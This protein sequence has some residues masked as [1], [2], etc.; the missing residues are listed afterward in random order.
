MTFSVF[1]RSAGV[2]AIALAAVVLTGLFSV[3]AVP[4][5][6]PTAVPKSSKPYSID[7]TIVPVDAKRQQFVSTVQVS[8]LSTGKVLLTIK[9]VSHIGERADVRSEREANG[10][11]YGFTI[12]IDPST[13]SAIYMLVIKDKGVANF[14]QKGTIYLKPKA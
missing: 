1:R 9:A 12:R 11:G 7:M 6:A 10:M 3:R 5:A 14:I 8:D 2:A 4:T 13:E